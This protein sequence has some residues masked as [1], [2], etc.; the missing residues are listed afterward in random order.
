MLDVKLIVRGGVYHI[1]SDANQ[2]ILSE[3]TIG[4][5]RKTGESTVRET[6]LGYF[7]RIDGLL[8]DLVSVSLRKEDAKTLGELKFAFD[9]ICREITS[10]WS[11]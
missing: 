5:N 3:N 9:E 4:K 8:K 7:P 10:Q 11:Y 6:V 2:F 1:R